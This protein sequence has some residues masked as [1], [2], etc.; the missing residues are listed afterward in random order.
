MIPNEQVYKTINIFLKNYVKKLSKHIYYQSLLKD[1]QNNRKYTWQIMK[2]ITGKTKFNSNRFPR[3]ININGKAIKKKS[4]I[5]D[6]T[7]QYFTNIGANLASKIQ[8]TSETF[9]DFLSPIER[10][11]YRKLTNF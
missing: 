11:E 5:T 2:E 6:I 7:I 3:S 10:M 8:N 4:H 1:C 9:E